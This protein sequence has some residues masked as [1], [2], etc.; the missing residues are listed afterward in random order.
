MEPICSLGLQRSSVIRSAKLSWPWAMFCVLGPTVDTVTSI[1]VT[2]MLP[3]KG[4]MAGGACKSS[5][6]I[7]DGSQEDRTLSPLLGVWQLSCLLSWPPSSLPLT[8]LPTTARTSFLKSMC[9]QVTPLPEAF[10]WLPTCC[11]NEAQGLPWWSSG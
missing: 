4:S 1:V 2:V 8:V 6:G 11:Q 3:G 7:T 5:R 9:Y 10:Q